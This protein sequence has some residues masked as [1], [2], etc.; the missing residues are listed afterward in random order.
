MRFG[1]LLFALAISAAAPC[2]AADLKPFVAGSPE[3][4]ARAHAGKPYVLVLWSVYC[5]PCREEMKRWAPL[6]KKYP[7]V[8][9]I[10]VSTDTPED[11][12]AA[13]K[14]LD[15]QG[16]AGV[17]MW[18]FADEFNERVRYAIDP[19]WRGE[20]PRTYLFDK[21]HR[22]RVFSGIVEPKLLEAWLEQQSAR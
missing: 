1:L 21:A 13:S 20:L 15:R 16:V 19:A 5:E 9:F 4:I 14:F 12:Q 18:A 11:R 10:V 22:R 3:A 17:Q 6:Q 2:P 8:A 7:K